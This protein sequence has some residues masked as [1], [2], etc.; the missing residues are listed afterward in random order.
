MANQ[1]KPDVNTIW[2]SSGLATAVSKAK[3][4][5]G[6]VAE[7]PEYDQFNGVI[8]QI[9]K[10][11]Q[12]INQ[13]GLALW[14]SLTTYGIGS[15]VKSP[16]DQNSYRCLQVDCLNIP[17]ITGGVVN[18]AWVRTSFTFAEISAANP[19]LLTGGSNPGFTLTPTP[20]IASYTLY[21][22]FPVQFNAASGA[23]PTINVSQRGARFIQQYNAAGQLVDAVFVAGQMG[24]LVYNGTVF[25]LLDSITT[26]PVATETV[27]GT[28]Q[29]ATNPEATAGTLDSRSLSPLKLKAVLDARGLWGSSITGSANANTSRNTGL[30]SLAASTPNAPT[31]GAYQMLSS[32]SGGDPTWQMQLAQGVG[33]NR[34]FMRSLKKDQTATTGWTEVY[35]TANNNMV[36]ASV[37]FYLNTPPVGWLK[38]NGAAVSRTTYAE[39]FAIIGT[40]FGAGDGSTTF[41][42]PDHRG[43]FPRGTDDTRG[44]DP[45]RL[46]GS[47][48]AQA[49]QSHSHVILDKAIT[50]SFSAAAS[51]NAPGGK[52]TGA[53]ELTGGTETR[54]RNIAKLYCIKY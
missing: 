45:G 10:F 18:A 3:Q 27:Q 17:P 36:G 33:F 15:L 11:Q 6:Y 35:T 48:Q 29:Y 14:D 30:Y 13:E 9:S 47:T 51:G 52:A 37:G 20:A 38:E 2:A 19:M 53:T 25:V 39:L 24:D 1:V 42:L 16:V 4:A 5:L 44:I 40:A 54:P 7:I 21:Q 22:R 8:Q 28:T 23:T 34:L 26:T 41:N 43:E 31:A 49:I 12:H 50:F 46:V 32:D